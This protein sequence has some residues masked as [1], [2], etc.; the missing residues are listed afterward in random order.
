MITCARSNGRVACGA[1]ETERRGTTVQRFEVIVIGSGQGGV[2]FATRSAEHGR[3]TLLVERDRLGGTCVNRGCTP[4]KTMVASARAAHVART[5]GR[6]GVRAEGVTVD[7]SAVV[8]RKDAIV[9]QWQDGIVRRIEHAGSALTSIG[10]HAR[11]TGPGEI[12]VGD[13]AYGADMVVVNVGARPAVP[14]VAGLETVPFLDSTSIMELR[15]TPEHLIVLGGGYIGCEFGQMFRRFGAAVTIVNRGAHILDREDEEVSAVLEEVFRAEAIDLRLGRQVVR[16][17][18][19]AGMLAVELDDGELVR[20][21]H[22]LVAVGRTPNTGGLDCDRAGIDL[23]R[24]GSI[25]IDDEYRTTATGVYAI[26]D[27]TGGPQFTHTSWDDHRILWDLLWPRNQSRRTRS[28]RL[29]PYAIFTDPPAARVGSSERE[30]K[31]RGIEYEVASMP[32][33]H[34]ARAIEVDETAGVLKVLVDPRSER[35]LGAAIVGLEAGE[36]IHVFV[37]LMQA[38]AT[39]RAI[40]DAEAVHPTL[41]EGLQSLVM[42]LDRYA[43][44]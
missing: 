7:L 31:Q 25:V 43:L 6:L 15:E 35:I 27:V 26:G 19:Q 38:G 18:G 42:R 29:I 4:T 16:V 11:F 9:R 41:A 24:R 10:G 23:D 12:S 40:V 33:G 13:E 20:G 2:P 21:S 32:F 14:P 5:A 1:F 36:L 39:A 17:S 3:K 8:D 30:A 22:L 34:I 44:S 37:A 28:D